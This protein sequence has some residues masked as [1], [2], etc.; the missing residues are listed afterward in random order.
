MTDEQ[1]REQLERPTAL[2][3]LNMALLRQHPGYE[4]SIESLHHN[5]TPSK[6][7]YEQL[8]EQVKQLAEAGGYEITGKDVTP[9]IEF[10]KQMA[11]FITTDVDLILDLAARLNI[12]LRDEDSEFALQAWNNL[13]AHLQ[14]YITSLEGAIEQSLSEEIELVDED[15]S[16]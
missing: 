15:Q 8:L 1:F 14:E 2:I 6:D 7:G 12:A 4:F 11:V 5:Q 9:Y 10:L 13:P 16:H 3:A